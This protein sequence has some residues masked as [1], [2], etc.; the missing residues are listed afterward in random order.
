M[1]NLAFVVTDPIKAVLVKVWGYVPVLFG[2]LVI[3]VVG[4]LVA[5]II[6]SL[7]VRVLKTVKL[8]MASDKAGVSNILAQGDIKITLSELIGVLTY[9]LVMLCVIVATLNALNLNVAAAL[10]SRIVAYIPKILVAIFVIVL[11]SF[12]AN[13]VGSIV[14]TSASNAGVKNAK[15]LGKVSQ[16]VLV[17]FSILIAIEQLNIATAIIALSFNIILMSLG[18]GLALAFGLGCKDIAGRFMQ[19]VINGIKK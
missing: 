14:R 15:M 8:D 3:L 11:G 4:W 7:V 6:E 10:L 9:W 18:L 12:L 17:I 19:D 2:A 16:T 13:L 5:K 1:D